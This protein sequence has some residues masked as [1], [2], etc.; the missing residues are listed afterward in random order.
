MIPGHTTPHGHIR[1]TEAQLLK[2]DIFSPEKP[3][4]FHLYPAEVE[5]IL[6]VKSENYV[7][8]TLTMRY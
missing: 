6:K 1:A 2:S 3:E 4:F 8:K 5:G 7:P